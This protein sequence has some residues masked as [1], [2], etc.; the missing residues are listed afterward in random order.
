M[1]QMHQEKH[2]DGHLLLIL[3]V[4]A[5]LAFVAASLVPHGESASLAQSA[6]PQ[7]IQQHHIQAPVASD[8]YTV[9]GPPTIRAA[10]IN[11][12]LCATYGGRR[13]TACG[14]GE[15]LYQLGVK[16]GIDPIYAAAFFKHESQFGTQGVAVS[17]HGLGN[18]RCSPGYACIGGYRAYVTWEEGYEDWYRLILYGYVQGSVSSQC[19]CRT[20]AQIIPVY[21]PPEDHNNVRAYITAVEAA[22]DSWRHQSRQ[23]SS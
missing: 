9:V 1:R 16:Y 11:A 10:S 15:A 19:P 17:T 20:V 3:L 22:V 23:P 12:L 5:A 6:P 7:Q 14:T 21:A 8:P 2:A 18:I 13:S 4:I